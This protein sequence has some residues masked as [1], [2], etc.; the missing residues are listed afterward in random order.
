MAKRGP[1]AVV[2]VEAPST[3]T[4]APLSAVPK[5]PTVWKKLFPVTVLCAS[6]AAAVPELIKLPIALLLLA[7]VTFN[8]EV[9]DASV[10][11]REPVSGPAVSRRQ[12]PSILAVCHATG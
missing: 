10:P 3:P 11:K 5:T 1:D 4:P 7:L 6:K 12:R 2:A 9:K 8:A